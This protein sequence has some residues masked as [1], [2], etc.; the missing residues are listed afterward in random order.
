MKNTKIPPIYVL[1]FTFF[2]T[3][4][5]A[6]LFFSIYKPKSY[7]NPYVTRIE[8]ALRGNIITGKFTLAKSE[9]IYVVSINPNYISPLKKKFFVDLFTIYTG[10]N[11]KELYRKLKQHKRVILSKVDKKTKQQLIYLRRILDKY[12]VFLSVNGIRRGYD[13]QSVKIQVVDG[14]KIFK[15]LFKRVYPYNDTFE[16]F[17]GSY[18][19]LYQKG[20]NGI[21][22][23]YNDILKPKKMEILFMIKML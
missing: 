16:P 21:E 4:F 8:S 12:R 18:S 10:V 23:Y 1:F 14:K 5:G 22:E 2:I 20:N 19:K 15:P 13:I 3:I 7:F 17:L 11:K 6:F 9:R